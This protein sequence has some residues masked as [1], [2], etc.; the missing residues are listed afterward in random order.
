M[1]V[2]HQLL[3]VLLSSVGVLGPLS[4]LSAQALVVAPPHNP[5]L[6]NNSTPLGK[7]W[8][9]LLQ[10][11]VANAL[12]PRHTPR[13]AALMKLALRHAENAYRAGQSPP[14]LAPLKVS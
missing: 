14:P 10:A 9:E 13:D 4:G 6:A 8:D 12:M 3:L 1:V 7:L 11:Q 2:P 5:A